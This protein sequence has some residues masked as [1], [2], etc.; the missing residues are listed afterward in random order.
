MAR[1]VL[2]SA[3]HALTVNLRC[4]RAALLTLR[5]IIPNVTHVVVSIV[6]FCLTF[7]LGSWAATALNAWRHSTPEAWRDSP[8]SHMGPG[9]LV[10]VAAG[11]LGRGLGGTVGKVGIILVLVGFVLITAGHAKSSRPR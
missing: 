6:Y 5:V 10:A 7:Y 4:A 2:P 9:V 1:T 8:F 11:F 3:R